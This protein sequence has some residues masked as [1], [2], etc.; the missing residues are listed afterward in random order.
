MLLLL[1]Q[2]WIRVS[3]SDSIP[4]L[5]F[6]AGSTKRPRRPKGATAGRRSQSGRC[7]LGTNSAPNAQP[8]RQSSS[9][10]KVLGSTSDS[11]RTAALPKLVL[12]SYDLTS[13]M[14]CPRLKSLRGADRYCR[15]DPLVPNQ[16]LRNR[17]DFVESVTCNF[18]GFSGFIDSCCFRYI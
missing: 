17:L 6:R 8:S 11:S 16:I 7:P 13:A 10:Q 3:L 9:N 5:L 1:L 15:A 18:F 12:N 2:D 14:V 4:P